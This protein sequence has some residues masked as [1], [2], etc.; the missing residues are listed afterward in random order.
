[1]FV[2]LFVVVFFAF[3][4]VTLVL[5]FPVEYDTGSTILLILNVPLPSALALNVKVTLDIFSC[6][7]L[8]S[9]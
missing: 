6:P 2:L 7:P 4:T 5:V 8:R 3:S 9:A 1:M